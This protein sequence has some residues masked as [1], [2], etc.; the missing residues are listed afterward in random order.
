MCIGKLEAVKD[1]LFMHHTQ[2]GT[3]QLVGAYVHAN[4]SLLVC[5]HLKG[6]YSMVIILAKASW[7]GPL[8]LIHKSQGCRGLWLEERKLCPTPSHLRVRPH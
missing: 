4:G 7:K 1:S 3:E 2:R 6:P 5:V 8:S